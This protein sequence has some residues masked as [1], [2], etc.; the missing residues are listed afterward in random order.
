MSPLLSTGDVVLLRGDLG[1]GK[2]SLVRGLIR[3]KYQDND[4]VVTSP[5]YLLDN[6]YDFDGDKKIHHMDL[7]RLPDGC[8]MTVLGIPGIFSNSLC[9]IEWPQRMGV[10]V[11][12][13]DYL[14]VDMTIMDDETRKIT[15]TPYTDSGANFE[16]GWTRM[17]ALFD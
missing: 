7:Y 17:K 3:E 4:M 14:D 5:S 6:T 9:L 12:P 1:A 2:T 10:D 15:L 11:Y 8:D 13:R 16:A